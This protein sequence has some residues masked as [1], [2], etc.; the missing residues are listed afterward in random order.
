MSK[1]KNLSSFFASFL[2]FNDFLFSE[3]SQSTKHAG[4]VSSTKGFHHLFHLRVV[5]HLLHHVHEITCTTE[6]S[7]DFGINTLLQFTHD[8]I[9]VSHK[10]ALVIEAFAQVSGSNFSDKGPQLFVLLQE[11][12]NFNNSST[13]SFG[14]SSYSALFIERLILVKLLWSH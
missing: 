12:F 9:G 13:R 14:N 1:Y 11:N 5:G 4:H 3:S 2:N 10:V 7:H 8:L 6:L